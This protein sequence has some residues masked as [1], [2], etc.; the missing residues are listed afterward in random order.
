[1]KIPG[2]TNANRKIIIWQLNLLLITRAGQKV[3]AFLFPSYLHIFR[4]S[5]FFCKKKNLC[6][7]H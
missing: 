2:N 7:I 4:I 5:F 6:L 1:M 3:R